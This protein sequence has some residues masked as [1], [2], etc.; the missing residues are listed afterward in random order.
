MLAEKL[1]RVM[2]LAFKCNN[3][4]DYTHGLKVAG[5]PNIFVRFSGHVNLLEVSIYNRGW[6]ENAGADHMYS[7]YLESP[8]AERKLD[9]IINLLEVFSNES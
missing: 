3:V 6:Y 1:A 5:K 4:N 7:F 9:E 2:A 8:E